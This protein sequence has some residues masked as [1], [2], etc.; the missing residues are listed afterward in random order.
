M[1]LPNSVLTFTTGSDETLIHNSLNIM[2]LM[3]MV[4]ETVLMVQVSMK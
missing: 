2:I 1:R 4:K 3:L